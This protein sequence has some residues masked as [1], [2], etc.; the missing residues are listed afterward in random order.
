MSIRQIANKLNIA[1]ST[2]GIIV[3]SP[4]DKGNPGTRLKGRC[5]RKRK[6][7]PYDDKVIIRNSVKD[8]KKN[9]ED[10]QRDM[11][12]DGVNICSST[13]RRRLL[14]IGR[15]TRKPVCKQLLT[16]AM[17]AKRLR[18]ARNYA[19]WTVDHWSKVIFSDEAHF[20]VH[21]YRSVVI[22]RSKIYPLRQG[23]IQQAPKHPQKRCFRIV[24]LQKVLA[25]L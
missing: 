17:E 14:E 20:E 15:T 6:T 4:E 22:R 7:T 2:V 18:W 16:A 1:K 10:L 24:L 25:D 11:V 13:I 21:G 23:H 12:S 9:S 8:P 19:A 5:C 3:K